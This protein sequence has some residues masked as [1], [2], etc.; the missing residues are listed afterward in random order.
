MS[1]QETTPTVQPAAGETCKKSPIAVA[2][3]TKVG[4]ALSRSAFTTSRLADFASRE[5]LTRQIGHTAASWPVVVV[6]ELVDNALDACEG[7]G[8]APVIDIAIGDNSVRVSD[9]G[10]GIAPETVERILDYAFKTSS[11]AAYVSPTRGQQGNDLQTLL[12]MSHALSGEPG[13]T[14][15]ESKGLQHRITFDVDPIS[16]EPRVNRQHVDVAVEQGTKITVFLAV[17]PEARVDLHNAAFDFGWINPHLTLSYSHGDDTFANGA[18]YQTWTKWRPTDPTSAHW[19]DLTS[20]KKLMA[21]E[22]NKARLGGSNQRT[23]ADFIGDFRGLASTA[24]RRD[25]CE[26]VN[27]SRQSLDVFFDRGDADISRLLV[28]MKAASRVVKPRDLGV[29]G[30]N[31]ILSVVGGEESA[32]RYKRTEVEVEGVP[33]LIEVGFG[34]RP[35]CAGRTIVCGLNWSIS[36]GGNPFKSL[37]FDGLGAILAEQRCGPDEP[38]GFFLHVASPRLTFLDRGKASVNL[39]HAVNQA[40]I[41]AIEFVTKD[42]AKQ[43]KAEERDH[44]ARLRRHDAMTA[45]SKPLSIKDAAY[46]VMAKAYAAASSDGTLPANAR[47][48]YYA[49]RGD[50]LRLTEKETLD[51]SN[52]TQGILIDYMNDHPDECSGWNVVFSDRGHFTEPHTGHVV[53]LGTLAVRQY[54][55]NY[56]K[57]AL[58]EGCFTDPQIE[59]RGPEGRFGG[60]L[61]IEKEGFEPLLKQARIAERFD[62]AIMSCKGMSVTAARELVDQTCARFKV[63]LYIL[64]DF[65]VAGF[66]I[67]SALHESNRRYQFMTDFVVHDLG[68][69]LDDVENLGLASE[70]VDLGKTSVT[71]LRNRLRRN[72][73]TEAEIAFLLGR[74]RVEL[75]AM[76]S[77]QFVDHLEAKLAEHGVGKVIPEN[78]RLE[79]AYRLFVR[80]ARA[81]RVAEAALAAMATETISPPPDLEEQVRAYLTMNPDVAWDDAVLSLAG[82]DN[83]P[84]DLAA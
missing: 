30:E 74:E 57:P 71:A 37:R 55:A 54:V 77:R 14:I 11:N 7:A 66:S 4:N 12:A 8:V 53:G 34:F 31:H 10:H 76:T 13:V 45:R 9:N 44:A 2:A 62:L 46:S 22:I 80:G 24:K 67:A 63:P 27:A 5:E 32:D 84:N 33:Y 68:L 42:W 17:P 41:A 23:V 81:R 79:E 49:A 47:Q 40:V 58:I 39:P 56:A 69:R 15:V 60:L 43:R 70:R 83:D 64:H 35:D 21:A 50:I 65:D 36:V 18:T 6:K 73:A 26:T 72:G 16:R 82:N 1:S 78:G 48:I 19:Y 25:I 38:I 29:I 52:F 28:E 51:A 61:Y 3:P 20:L 75:N 59:T